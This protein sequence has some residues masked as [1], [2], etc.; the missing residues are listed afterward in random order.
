M[1]PL[2]FLPGLLCDGALWTHQMQHLNDVCTPQVMDLTQHDSVKDMAAN[3]LANA[4]ARFALAGLSMGG[5]VA[6]E[7]LRQAPERVTQLALLNTQARADSDETRERRKGLIGLAKTGKFKGVTPKLLP[8]LVHE[9]RL[10][11][12]SITEV[13]LSM[14]E[15]VGRDAFVRQQHAILGRPDSR[16]N[17]ASIKVPTLVVVGREDALTPL[18]L[19]QEMA[20]GIAG[21]KLA[22][23]EE[24]GHLSPLE[25][26]QATTAILRLWLMSS[27]SG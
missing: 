6:F 16:A 27:F 18:P 22:L 4:P 10:Q 11:D 13:V 12:S 20:G 23:I 26:P 14:A 2:L 17:L 5:Y 3:V 7:I 1:Q 19:A 25:R 9:S 21:A 24:C 8:L 15:R